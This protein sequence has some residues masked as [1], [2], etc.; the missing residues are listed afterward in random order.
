MLSQLVGAVDHLYGYVSTFRYLRACDVFH[1]V[2]CIMYRALKLHRSMLQPERRFFNKVAHNHQQG[3]SKA[4]SS[5][6]LWNSSSITDYPCLQGWGDLS[7]V[8]RLDDIV[9]RHAESL[10]YI[11]QVWRSLTVLSL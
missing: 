7:K 3:S 4:L 11:T 9:R 1:A 5:R 10:V 8:E 6:V 2:V